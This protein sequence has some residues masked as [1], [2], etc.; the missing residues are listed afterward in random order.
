MP[1]KISTAFT[2]CALTG[3]AGGNITAV[4]RMATWY[5]GGVDLQDYFTALIAR[6][7]ASDIQNDGT[8]KDGFYKPTRAL[9]LRH[10]NVMR[11][12]HAKPLAKPMLKASWKFVVE[13]VPP[14]WLVLNESQKA[15]LKKI[16]D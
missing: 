5:E 2:L 8:D 3:V 12:L 6:V 9:L 11:D 4:F 15:E 10:L 16:L 1:W 14:E 7:E 13:N